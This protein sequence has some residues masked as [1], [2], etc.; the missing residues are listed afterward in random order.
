MN[1]ISVAVVVLVALGVTSACK[2]ADSGSASSADVSKD[3]AF[4][5]D[6]DQWK[7][8]SITDDFAV[9]TCTLA[10]T[11]HSEER[12][13]YHIEAVA[14]DMSG[15]QVGTGSASAAGVAPGGTALADVTINLSGDTMSLVDGKV[16]LRNVRHTAS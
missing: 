10:I 7:S 1:K 14:Y 5:E 9:L 11:N 6:N 12:S 13:N 4:A 3:V 8:C 15:T 2:P 16:E